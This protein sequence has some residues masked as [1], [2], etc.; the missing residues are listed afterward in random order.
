MG[1]SITF[2][3]TVEDRWGINEKTVAEGVIPVIKKV[4]KEKKFPLIDLHKA[5]T[6]KPKM[7]PDK[8]LLSTSLPQKP[9]DEFVEDFISAFSDTHWETI[10]LALSI[11][12]D[13]SCPPR[14]HFAFA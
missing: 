14:Y 9:Q 7:F 11:C 12:M 5:L 13:Y 4:A 10:P 3:A 1:D 8:I 2:G 6:G